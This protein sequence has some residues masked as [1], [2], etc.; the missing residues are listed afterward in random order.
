MN[1]ILLIDKPAGIT[2]FSVVA[3]VRRILTEVTGHKHKV[4]HAGTLDPF[5]TGL[6]IVLVGK[7]TK[8]ANLFLKLDKVYL[9][10]LI[11]GQ[12]SSTIDPE[13]EIKYFSNFVPSTEALNS[14][15]KRFVGEIEQVPP[16]F[17]AIKVNG[18]R[19]Y[20]LARRGEAVILKP[21]PVSIYSIEDIK[22]SYPKLQF[23]VH[24]SSGTYIRSLAKD[25]G[26]VLT[27][28]AY[29]SSLRR[30]SID[31]YS[32]KQATKLDDLNPENI[33]EKLMDIPI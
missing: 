20:K 22:Y 10:E 26:E 6:L 2:S 14:T 31:K 17:S 5:A 25:I 15:L 13:G 12:T 19:S 4:G 11:F 27:T 9:A 1:G 23:T 3:R 16:A 29:L 8:S 24:V 7:A 33:A 32:L 18:V 21:R 28:G 30:I